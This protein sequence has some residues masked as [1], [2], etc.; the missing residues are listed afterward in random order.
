MET[1]IGFDRD[2]LAFEQD[3]N[4]KYNVMIKREKENYQTGFIFDT[5][6]LLSSYM[7]LVSQTDSDGNEK[8]GVI[9]GVFRN[10]MYFPCI[11]DIIKPYKYIDFVQAILGEEIYYIKVSGEIYSKDIFEIRFK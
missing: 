10:I 8:Y 11:F 3:A 6:K 2:L 4:G 1:I 7:L 9:A 5:I